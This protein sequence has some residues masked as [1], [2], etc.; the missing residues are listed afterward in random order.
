[1]IR[2]EMLNMGIPH[3]VERLESILNSIKVDKTHNLIE[4]EKSYSQKEAAF[5]IL[6]IYEKKKGS[7]N[8]MAPPLTAAES[9]STF[10]DFEFNKNGEPKDE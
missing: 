2:V 6:V 5:H 8:F 1:M 7:H 4:M 9:P 3:E 10:P